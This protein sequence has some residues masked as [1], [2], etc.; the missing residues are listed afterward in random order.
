MASPFTGS[1]ITTA[2]LAKLP[3]YNVFHRQL[4]K[5]QPPNP[6][7]D[8]QNKHVLFRKNF[9]AGR[10]KDAKLHI[11]ADDYYKVYINGRFVGQG[12]APAYYSRYYYNTIDVAPY[13]VDGENTIAVHTYYQ[14]LINRVWVSG[15][16]LHGLLLELVADGTSILTSDTS[17]KVHEHTGYASCGIVGYSTQFMEHY[18][19]NAPECDF[20][21]PRFDDSG[22]DAAVV[23]ENIKHNV[24]Q[25][26]SKQL[27]FDIINPIQMTRNGQ[28]ILIDFGA[29]YVGYFTMVARGEKGSIVTMRFGQELNEDGSLRFAIRANCT[30]EEKMTLSGGNDLLNQFDYKAFRYAEIT[31]PEGADATP[32]SLKLISRHYPFNLTAKPKY[33]DDACLAIWKLCTE[34]LHYG[35]Q[36][37]IQD[38]MD[39]EKGYYMGDGCYSLFTYCLLQNDFMLMEKFIDDCLDTAFVNRGLMTCANCSFMQE[40]AEYPLI[41]ITIILPYLQLTKRYEFIAE[42]YDQL[43]DVMDFYREQYAQADGLLNNLDKWCV[44]EWPKNLRDGYDADITEGRVCTVKHTAIN[45]YYVGAVKCMNKIANLI[46]KPAYADAQP[47]QE[48]FLK[49]FYDNEQHL[50]TDSEPSSHISFAANAY[51]AFYDLFPDEQGKQ[52]FIQ[53]VREKR[54]TASMLFVTFPMFSFLAREGEDELLYSLLTEPTAW[55]NIIA[56]GGVHTFEAWSKDLKWNTS[57]FHL[58]LSFGATFLTEWP[59]KEAFTF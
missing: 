22:W 15:D 50:F 28:T 26:P 31:L 25:Q 37:V 54:L 16:N 3:V 44:V 11:T 38:C 20:F 39:R 34:S 9:I 48:A 10:A 19:A 13:L 4:D 2:E 46:G 56:E 41:M 7:A 59:I 40:I 35:V 42:R 6:H 24:A 49:A 29:V 33:T 47:L 43:K 52:A 45:A 55:L 57:L 23:N 12:P 53:M 14:G 18:D 58:T 51:S 5:N 27:V 36:E 30:Y 32:E 17:F 1:W 21:K 8:V